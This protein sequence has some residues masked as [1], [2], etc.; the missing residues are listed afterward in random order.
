MIKKIWNH[1]EEY[2]LVS[3]LM[4]TVLLIFIQIIMRYIFHNSLS[5]SEELARYIF[6][7]QIWLGASFAVKEHRHLKIE[8][9]LNLLPKKINKYAELLSLFIWFCFSAFLAYKGSE[10]VTLLIKHGQVSPAMRIPMFYAYSSVPVGCAFMGVRLI[11]EIINLFKNKL[12]QIKEV[13]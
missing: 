6:L 5:W 9:F 7:W 1:F 13:D 8:A 10:L 11:E 3:S 12:V 2:I 4:F